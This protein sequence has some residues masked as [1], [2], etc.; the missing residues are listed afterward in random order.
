M[1]VGRIASTRLQII[2]IVLGDGCCGLRMSD[3][4]DSNLQ[5]AASRSGH[6]EIQHAC[7]T[8]PQLGRA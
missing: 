4:H 2:M 6:E 1:P 7:E 5:L 3:Y 8:T